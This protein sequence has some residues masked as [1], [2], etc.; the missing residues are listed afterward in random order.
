[1]TKKHFVHLNYIR[2]VNVFVLSIAF[3]LIEIF[4]NCRPAEW[5][6]NMYQSLRSHVGEFSYDA[7][8]ASKYVPFLDPNMYQ[9]LRIY[10]GEFSSPLR[11]PVIIICNHS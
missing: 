5:D 6:P 9:G 11:A 3:Y 8:F 7:I 10:V 4:L 2:V 1:M